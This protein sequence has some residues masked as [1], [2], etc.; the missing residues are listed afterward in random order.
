MP[1]RSISVVWK[2]M[3]AAGKTGLRIASGAHDHSHL[4]MAEVEQRGEME[5][6]VTCPDHPRSATTTTYS[7]ACTP[8]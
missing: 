5:M 3:R 4:T 8:L 2:G 6:D 7:L 1:G